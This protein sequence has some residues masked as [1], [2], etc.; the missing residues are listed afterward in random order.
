MS[1]PQFC[2]DENFVF[3][4]FASGLILEFIFLVYLKS[5]KI[6]K[7]YFKHS[8]F[9]RNYFFKMRKYSINWIFK[10]WGLPTCLPSSSFLPLLFKKISFDICNLSNFKSRWNRPWI[11]MIRETLA[12][13]TRNGEEK[14][15]YLKH[16]HYTSIKIW[17]DFF[18]FNFFW[19]LSDF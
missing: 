9:D 2:L 3:A 17:A 12:K 16:T 19:I 14:S 4:V 10:I 1:T 15:L 8:I 11:A 7:K 13:T 5:Q 18:F 6:Q